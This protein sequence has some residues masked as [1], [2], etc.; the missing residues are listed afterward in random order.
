MG[1]GKREEQSVAL[2]HYVERVRLWALC[3]I[4]IHFVAIAL[5]CRGCGRVGVGVSVFLL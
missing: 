4:S 3:A 5:L 2:Y 1:N